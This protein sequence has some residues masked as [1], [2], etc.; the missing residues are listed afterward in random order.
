MSRWVQATQ[1]D[2]SPV[3][4]NLD[5]CTA[6]TRD[7]IELEGTKTMVTRILGGGITAAVVAPN[8]PMVS[9]PFT[10][11]VKEEPHELAKLKPVMG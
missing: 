5:N 7:E 10:I 8:Q 11:L 4:I 3:L 9:V 1:P 6:I 2:D